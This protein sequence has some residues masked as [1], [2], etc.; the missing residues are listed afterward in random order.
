MVYVVAVVVFLILISAG[1]I[2]AGII[3]HAR[4]RSGQ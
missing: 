4:N 1:Q 3:G 2:A